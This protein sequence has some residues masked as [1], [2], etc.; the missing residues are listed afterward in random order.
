MFLCDDL[1]VLAL[2]K[3][4]KMFTAEDAEVIAEAAEESGEFQIK[5]LPESRHDSRAT[6]LTIAYCTHKLEFDNVRRSNLV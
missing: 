3:A 5:T 1:D 4:L 6:R 2:N